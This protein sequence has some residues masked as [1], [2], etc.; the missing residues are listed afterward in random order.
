MDSRGLRPV[1]LVV[2]PV[3]A[4]GVV[5]AA[6]TPL[7][8]PAGRGAAGSGSR[9]SPADSI[10][11]TKQATNRSPNSASAPWCACGR[12]I[13]SGPPKGVEQTGGPPTT[14]AR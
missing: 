5:V 9:A 14:S 7:F 10:A 12:I 11:A 4:A 8:E 6:P 2:T 3:A 13:A 1:L